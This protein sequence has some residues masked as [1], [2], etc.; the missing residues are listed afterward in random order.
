MPRE[1]NF[2]S[3]YGLLIHECME[4]FFSKELDIFELS[5]YYLEYYDSFV[6]TPAPPSFTDLGERYKREGLIFF[7]NFSFPIDKYD[8]VLIEDKID[9]ELDGISFVAKPDLVLWNKEEKKNV[10]YDYKTAMPFKL[11]KQTNKETTDKKK[12]DGYHNQMYVYA[13]ALR[14]IRNIPIEQI[15]LWFTRAQREVSIE[16]LKEEED[17]AMERI[18]GIV[19][20]IKDEKAFTPNPSNPYFCYNL[21]GVRNFCEYK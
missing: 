16:W 10:L 8:V 20:S 17:K 11:N 13:Y 14:T 21:C 19:N 15:V 2:F 3:E 18:V 6:K 7:D 4:K 5:Q 1:E 9:F 12:I